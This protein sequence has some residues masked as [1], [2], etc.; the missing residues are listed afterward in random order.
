MNNHEKYQTASKAKRIS[1]L[2]NLSTDLCDCE[3]SGLCNPHHKQIITR[4]LT[5]IE[6]SKLSKVFKNYL[7]IRKAL[8]VL[9][10]PYAKL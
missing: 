10:K 1:S 3:K 2:F 9:L 6:N 5:I 4:D 8:L 7:N